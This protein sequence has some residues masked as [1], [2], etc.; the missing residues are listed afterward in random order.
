M[1]NFF[2]QKLEAVYESETLENWWMKANEYS[3]HRL[4]R[5]GC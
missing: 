5:R 3:L 4:G 1:R 2:F